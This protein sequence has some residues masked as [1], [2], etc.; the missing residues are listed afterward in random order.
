M[1][2]YRLVWRSLKLCAGKH[3]AQRAA[4]VFDPLGLTNG[5]GCVVRQ[6]ARVVT[7][8]ERHSLVVIGCPRAG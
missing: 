4:S 5:D 1:R 2:Q 3:K 6:E 7:T 8:T